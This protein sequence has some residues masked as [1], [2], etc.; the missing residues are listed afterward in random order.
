MTTPI[1]LTHRAPP[2]DPVTPVRVTVFD[3]TYT[4]TPGAVADAL[5]RDNAHK[6]F[7]RPTTTPQYLRGVVG[8]A[9]AHALT[10]YDIRS[11]PDAAVPLRA[12]EI[13]RDCG[14]A[15]ITVTVLN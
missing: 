9:R 6:D 1:S 5:F 10:A 13:L 11:T 8:R 12:L 7:E 4:G 3:R 2:L 15:T 14:L